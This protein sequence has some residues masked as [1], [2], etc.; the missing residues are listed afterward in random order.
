MTSEIAPARGLGSSS[1]AIVAG[2]ELANLLGDLELT[3]DAKIQWASKIEGH[4]DNVTPAIV[5]GFVVRAVLDDRVYW[6]KIPFLDVAMVVCVPEHQL[7]TIQSR[8]VLPT[9]LPFKQAVKVSS[10]ANVLLASLQKG[11]LI[12]AGKMIESDIFHEPYRAKLIPELNHVRSIGHEE[13]AY[14]TYISG[15][16]TAVM[17]MI[18]REYARNLRERLQIELPRCRTHITHVGGKE[19]VIL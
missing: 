5:G 16:G 14:G 17:T 12:T 18:S 8:T 13:A 19:S 10:L 1:A 15:A 4:P 11:N 9:N 6:K 2:I 3:A 7:K